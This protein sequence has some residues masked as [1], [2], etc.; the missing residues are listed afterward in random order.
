MPSIKILIVEDE[1]IIA[2]DISSQLKKVGYEILKV[3]NA[4]DAIHS[5]SADNP[6]I[7]LMDIHLL[8]DKKDGIDVV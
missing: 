2:E 8:G 3:H 4:N 6:D 5:A 1:L 7:I